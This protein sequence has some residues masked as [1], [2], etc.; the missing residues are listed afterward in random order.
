MVPA[1]LTDGYLF[2]IQGFSVHDGPGCRTLIFLKGCSLRCSWCSNPEG[3]QYFPEPVYSSTKCIFD[4]LCIKACTKM[5][6]T[7]NDHDLH[8]EK[9]NCRECVTYECAAACCTGALKI[10]GYRN[11][12][13]GLMKK[14]QRD[15]HYW[16]SL[17]GITLTGGEPYLQPQFVKTILQQCHQSYI[18][19]AVETCGNVAWNSIRPSL[20][21]LDWVFYDLKHMD[22]SRH[23]AMT[24]E[25]NKLIL[26]NARK[27][28][29]AFTGRLVFR[30]PVV[31]GYND[32]VEN[33][34]QLSGFLNSIGKDEINILPLHHMGREKYNLLGKTYYTENFTPPSK[35]SLSIIQSVFHDHKINC[36]IGT[37]TPF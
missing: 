36:Y 13:Y 23:K 10:A 29:T 27:L 2:D 25:G 18:H 11:S 7:D 17:G 5:A 3:L 15:R 26:E 22:D 1:K 34:L 6:V 21:F 4:S 8:F 35:E 12:V 19:T 20:K 28:A 24:G 31:P 30:M 14:I 33:I 16:G 9:R 37:E 32:N